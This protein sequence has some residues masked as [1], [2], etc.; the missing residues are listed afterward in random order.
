MFSESKKVRQCL[1][2]YHI[3]YICNHSDTKRVENET[4]QVQ[5]Q[6]MEV[7]NKETN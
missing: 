2:S 1:G 7:N 6:V 5:R 3:P 4:H